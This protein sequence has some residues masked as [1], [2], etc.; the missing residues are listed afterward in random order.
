MTSATD[1]ALV[2]STLNPA[3]AAGS[4]AQTSNPAP[5]DVNHPDGVW[6]AMEPA[7]RVIAANLEGI[8]HLRQHPLVYLPKFP[9]ERD[10]S[11]ALRIQLSSYTPFLSRLVR[12]AAGLILR[13][14]IHLETDDPFWEE[15]RKNV[16]RCG[17]TL[18][19]FAKML[20]LVSLAYGH[21]SVLV[22]YPSVEARTL[23]E[24]RDA[25][26]T[27][28]LLMVP[29]W[30]TIGRRQDP[31][32]GFGKLQQVRIRETSEVPD[33]DYGVRLENRVRVLYPGRYELWAQAENATGWSMVTGGALGLKEIPLA[34][35]YSGRTGFLTSRPP[36]LDCA[37]LNL[38][39]YQRRT[40]LTMALVVGAQPLLLLM[41]FDE[42]DDGVALS[43]NNAIK[44]PINGDGKYAEPSGAS[45]E[46]LQIELDKIA[47]QILT[48]GVAT[49]AR[50][51]DF[52]E[53]GLAKG[54][55][56]AESNSMLAGVLR[57]L[58]KT[59][60]Q[61]LGWVAEYA[62]VEAPTVI[63]DDDFDH[64]T[65]EPTMVAQLVN[66]KREGA[67]TLELLLQ[68]LQSGGIVP[69]DIDLEAV[70]DQ[71]EAEAAERME[72][73]LAKTEA[74]AKIAAKNAPNTAP[75]QPP[76]GKKPAARR[77]AAA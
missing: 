58:E 12:G 3:T 26:A 54:L 56:R 44:L 72:Q 34:T 43:V 42:D 27:P 22:D 40:D 23:K 47:D 77:P 59:L 76:A 15:W 1:T 32:V 30:A 46:A 16:D 36:L 60:Q 25:A 49:L 4:L 64:Q 9:R 63:I 50:Q 66:L 35:T 48:L 53:S 74:E 71:A 55:D 28:Y 39:H 41:G 33:G 73:E 8:K 17:T 70:I 65:L 24:E 20:L 62:G 18:D 69:E 61:A 13:K 68:I 37:E 6:F 52:Q 2:A 5:S 45:Y 7:W 38:T 57:D 31:R 67:L 14:S 19:D 10:D 29:P 21:S 75:G 11:Y 51:Q